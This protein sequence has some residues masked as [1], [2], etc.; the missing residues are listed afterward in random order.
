MTSGVPQ[1]SVFET[2]LFSMFTALVGILINSFGINYHQ[3]ANVTQ[4]NTV[5]DSNSAQC[6]A[7]LSSCA[8]TVSGW[9][10]SINLLLNPIK[11]KA[12]VVGTRQ[13]VSNMNIF[14]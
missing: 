1:G 14:N 11:T 3:F 10:I 4:L 12:L 6:L 9:H 13:Q 8:D 7:S 5:I 2:L